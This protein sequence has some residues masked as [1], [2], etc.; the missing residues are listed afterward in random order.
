MNRAR[1][2]ITFA[3]LTFVASGLCLMETVIA[4]LISY[5]AY[6]RGAIRGLPFHAYARTTMI[7]MVAAGI[8]CWAGIKL[9]PKRAS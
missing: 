6:V 2:R 5:E 8:L 4:L 9:W 1:M 7:F 3:I